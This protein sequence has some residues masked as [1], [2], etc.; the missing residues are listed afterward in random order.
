MND[1]PVT[2]M[3]Q[4][5]YL[6]M[7]KKCDWEYVTRRGVSGI[8]G[9]VA[10][11][12]DGKLLLVEQFRPPLG[13]NVIELPAGLA[14]DIA[15]LRAETLAD[16][17]ARELLEETGYQAQSMEYIARGANSAGL[18]DELLTLF[19]AVGVKKISAPAS[20]GTEQIELHEIPV[21]DVPRWLAARIADGLIIDLKIYAGLFFINK[22]Q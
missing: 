2:V 5:R 16:A 20:E 18:S 22:N 11:T 12:D 4:G 13:R 7:V 17:A 6:R 1:E 19:R 9:I 8:V 15:G 3:A 14:G 10:V 21:V